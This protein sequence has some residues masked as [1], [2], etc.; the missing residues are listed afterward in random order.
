MITKKQK[1]ILFFFLWFS[2]SYFYYGLG[3]NQN[4]RL[5]QI[6]A[7]V[8]NGCL[9]ITKFAQNTGD[10][11]TYQGRYYPAKPPGVPFLAVPIYFVLFNVEKVIGLNP[12]SPVLIIRNAWIINI[13]T[14]AL[15]AGFTAV[16][17][18]NLIIVMFPDYKEGWLLTVLAYSLG[19]LIFPYSILFYVHQ[20]TAAFYLISFY[21]LFM[22]KRGL[23]KQ[24]TVNL[25]LV[26]AGFILGWNSMVDYPNSII[27]LFM[28]VYLIFGVRP[29]LRQGCYF[30]MGVAVPVVIYLL[31]N[32]NIFS[33]PFET[34]LRFWNPDLLEATTHRHQFNW[35]NLKALWGLTLSPYRGLFF[36]SPIL[37]LGV[38]GL[39]VLWLKQTWRAECYLWTAIILFYL[40][41][42]MSLYYWQAGWACGPRYLIGMLPFLSMPIVLVV[43][44]NRLIG[45]LLLTIS[46]A[47][48]LVAVSVRPEVPV[49][50]PYIHYLWPNFLAGRLSIDDFSA[51]IYPDVS[52]F[53][54]C[55]SPLKF[56]S[57]NIGE[58]LGFKGLWSLLPL[59][60][61]WGVSV[62]YL[63]LA[64][65]DRKAP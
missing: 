46:I 52:S 2:Y 25:Y 14:N 22:I 24:K 60:V 53:N 17:M 43:R 16:V 7:I 35:P 62:S 13:A 42:N 34:G 51:K 18:A 15:L 20:F 30:S 47:M 45:I 59:L 32:W 5:D 31:Y 19:T 11:I 26:L 6:W 63:T 33:N 54:L 57:F 64:G 9:E 12:I 39:I 23:V 1:I 8:E 10:F 38:A 27:S 65:R 29:S 28:F 37:L 41:L 55:E 21:L 56:T 4:S 3:W 44:K 58:L 61:I 40:I 48:M 49:E 50:N 36:S